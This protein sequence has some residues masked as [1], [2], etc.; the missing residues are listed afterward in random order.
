[1]KIVLSCFVLASV[2]LLSACPIRNPYNM[3]EYTTQDS[4]ILIFKGEEVPSDM[5]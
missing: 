1:M 3:E 5:R 2:F 4:Y